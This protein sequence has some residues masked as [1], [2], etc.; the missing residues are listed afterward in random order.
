MEK[1]GVLGG[2]G[3]EDGKLSAPS[4]TSRK[5]FS[6]SQWWPFWATGLMKEALPFLLKHR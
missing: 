2:G 1:R 5:L 4:A 3:G 6:V